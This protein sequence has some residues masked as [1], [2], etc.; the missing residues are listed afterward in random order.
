MRYWVTVRVEPDQTRPPAGAL[1]RVEVRDTGLADAVSKLVAA[2]RT[3]VLTGEGPVLG[4]VDVDV[5]DLH[6]GGQLT[7]WG[8]ISSAAPTAA[9][10]PGDWLTVQSFPLPPRHETAD[11]ADPV[12]VEIRL[13]RIS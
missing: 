3:T 12:Q 7:V 6:Q 2:A 5:P 13:R 4:E 11:R 1:I 9:I 8:H 10:R